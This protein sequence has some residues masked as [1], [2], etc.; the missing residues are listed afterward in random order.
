MVRFQKNPKEQEIKKSLREFTLNYC[1]GGRAV[2]KLQG[3][4]VFKPIKREPKKVKQICKSGS[5][6][7]AVGS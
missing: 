7:P 3:A 6:E 5:Q 2:K 1:W 4:G